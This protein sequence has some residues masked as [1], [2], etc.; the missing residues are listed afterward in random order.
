MDGIN[1]GVSV[2]P[3]VDI[4]IDADIDFSTG[5]DTDI[6]DLDITELEVA[7]TSPTCNGGFVVLAFVERGDSIDIDIDEEFMEATPF[8]PAYS[9]GLVDIVT[10]GLVLIADV[11]TIAASSAASL[12]VVCLSFD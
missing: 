5:A 2:E 8:L 6:F 10:T 3:D 12:E 9:R 11:M 1:P 7:D 4:L